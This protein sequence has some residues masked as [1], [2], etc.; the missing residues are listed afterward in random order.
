MD[1]AWIGQVE[2]QYIAGT[3]K[4]EFDRALSHASAGEK[5]VNIANY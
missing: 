1:H 3:T 2:K 5:L 4:E